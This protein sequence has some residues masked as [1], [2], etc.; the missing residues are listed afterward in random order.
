MIALY[1]KEIRRGKM[2]IEEVP[3]EWREKVRIAL[4]TNKY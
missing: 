2:T 4:Q 1:V 3:E